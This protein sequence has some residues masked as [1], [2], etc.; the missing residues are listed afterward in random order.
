[1]LMV[2]TGA[3]VAEA[4]P[5]YTARGGR[6]CDNCHSLP[7]TWYDPPEIAQRKCTL[8][9]ASCH[10]D[11]NGGGLRN[12]SGRYYGE[13]T[14][15]MFGSKNR[16]ID[17]QNR[18]LY[19]LMHGDP[20]GGSASSQPASGPIKPAAD[21]RDPRDANAPPATRGLLALGTPVLAPSEMAWLDGRYDDMKADPLL[22][23]GGD[24]R[25]GYWS[26]GPLFFPMQADIYAAVHPVEHLTIMGS[27]GA[28][29]RTR[30]LVFEESPLDDQPRFG[31]RDLWVMAHELPYLGFARAGRFL[32]AFGTRVADHTAYTRRPFGMSQEE[33]ANRVIGAELGFTANYPYGSVSA[34]KPSTRDAREPFALG[35]GWGATVNGGWRGLGAQIGASA[36]VR[37]RPLQSGGDT[38]DVSLQ[39][40]FNPWFYWKN[41]PLT[42]LG[43]VAAGQHQRALSGVE[44]VQV[45]QYHQLAWTVT[46]GVIARLRYDSWDP[47]TQVTDDHIYRPGLG[48]DWTIVP[49]ITLS[50]DGRLGLTPNGSGEDL[51]DIFAQIHGWF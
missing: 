29:G 48:L 43:E 19:R 2:V 45:A 41:L 20:A 51:A 23:L 11:P 13:A 27:F 28:R 36:Q 10:V 37:Q 18:D 49:G 3:S 34:W 44:T 25:F 40:G 5:L 38:V 46:S 32:P 33:P 8:S 35:E 42:Y 31:V 14:L 47:D 30:S 6:T 9:C 1:M 39:W 17:D 26:Q 12:V 15:P 21:Q 24:L 16:P 7:N 22:L 50:A 4:L